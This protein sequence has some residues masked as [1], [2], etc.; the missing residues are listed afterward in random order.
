MSVLERLLGGAV[1]ALLVAGTAASVGGVGHRAPRPASAV[2]PTTTAAGTAS[3]PAASGPPGP[4]SDQLRSGLITPTDMGGYYRVDEASATALLDSAGCLAVLQPAAGQSGRAVTGLLGPDANSVPTVVEVVA[5]YPGSVAADV[6][7]NVVAAIG[8]CPS[9]AF[10]FGGTPVRAPI[11]A[12]SI[13]PVGDSV[14][15]WSGRFDIGSLAFSVQVGA[16]LAGRTVIGLIW[17]D[18]VPPSAAVM[19]NFT[20]TVSLAIGKLA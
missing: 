10:T 18:R 15:V 8:G 1:A 19:G 14:H 7:R 17:I 2:A 5:S 16:V 20:S 9:L 11:T 12:G 13:P 6:Y 3:P 4:A